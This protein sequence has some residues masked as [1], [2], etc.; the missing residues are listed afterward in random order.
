VSVIIDVGCIFILFL[1]FHVSTM[2]E[3]GV[4]WAK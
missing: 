2:V 3:R 1:F 4:E